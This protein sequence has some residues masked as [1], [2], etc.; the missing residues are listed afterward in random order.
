[1]PFQTGNSLG[2]HKNHRNNFKKESIVGTKWM[3]KDGETVRVLAQDVTKMLSE[4]WTFGRPKWSKEAREKHSETLRGVECEARWKPGHIPWQ[5]GKKMPTHARFAMT[6]GRLAKYGVTEEQVRDAQANN[7]AWCSEHLI[8]E[9]M[10]SFTILHN[11]KRSTRCKRSHKKY[12]PIY[13]KQLE[14]QGGKCGMC[15][16]V[17]HSDEKA[18]CLDHDHDCPE[19]RHTRKHE[20]LLGCTCSRGL[21]CGDCNLRYGYIEPVFKKMTTEPNFPLSSWESK[22]WRYFRRYQKDNLTPPTTQ[23]TITV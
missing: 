12:N 21:I 19:P 1:M 13:R 3:Q 23:S 2:S 6:V 18:L 16:E 20:P 5:K 17:I 15:E 10:D 22:A 11:G 4:S 8:F 7:M 9:S 14:D